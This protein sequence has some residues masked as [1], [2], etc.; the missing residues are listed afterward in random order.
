MRPKGLIN[1]ASYDQRIIVLRTLASVFY[2]RHS[3]TGKELNETMNRYVAFNSSTV[4]NLQK[5]KIL[6]CNRAGA[7]STWELNV[8]VAT[9]LANIDMYA[10]KMVT[11]SYQTEYVERR[12]EAKCND[13]RKALTEARHKIAELEAEIQ[14]LRMRKP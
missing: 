4:A 7:H 11:D 9:L 13:Y 12:R 6:K 14:R 5:A 8:P 10:I 1:G 3:Y 2:S